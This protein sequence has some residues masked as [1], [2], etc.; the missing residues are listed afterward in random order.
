MTQGRNVDSCS[1]LW[2]PFK[3]SNVAKH[4]T[5]LNLS[6]LAK[7]QLKLKPFQAGEDFLA[8]LNDGVQ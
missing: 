6:L 7:K 3:G 5:Q 8:S 1:R 2:H 4:Q